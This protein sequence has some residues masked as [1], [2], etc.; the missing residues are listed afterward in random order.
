MGASAADQL[1]DSTA[2]YTVLCS[3]RL[4]TSET[5]KGLCSANASNRVSSR[6]STACVKACCLLRWT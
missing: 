3:H 1:P 6:H 5:S 4:H 2:T